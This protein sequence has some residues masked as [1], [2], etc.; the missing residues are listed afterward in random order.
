MLPIK[1]TA[2]VILRAC[3]A[4]L[5]LVAPHIALAADPAANTIQP[6]Q[7]A[8]VAHDSGDRQFLL[9]GGTYG[10][11]R[12]SD[13]WLLGPSGWSL[14]HPAAHP[15]ERISSSLVY[16][17]IRDEYLLF[18]G[19]VKKSSA[20]PCASGT[21]PV[22]L[23]AE[24]FCKDTWTFKKGNWTRMSPATTPPQRELHA[25]AFDAVSGQVVLFGGVGTTSSAPLGDTWVWNGTTWKQIITAHRPP[26]RF[27]HTMAYDPITQRVVLFGGD[28]GSKILNDTWLWNGSDWLPAAPQTTPPDFYTGAGMEYSSTLGKMVLFSGLT[29]NGT[30]TGTPSKNS[31]TWDGSQWKKLPLSSFKL[32][33]D[34]SKLTAAQATKALLSSGTP[35]MLWL[36]E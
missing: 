1:P 5:A 32:I 30:R 21:V 35:T 17:S 7:F 10:T 12:Y 19:R 36:S 33:T 25:M 22:G 16:D 13:T 23:T 6:R 34:F 27:L 14:Q 15:A 9:F 24:L 28:G 2:Q 4:I 26:A 20:T 29:W 18:G 8:A 11:T 3:G 31:W